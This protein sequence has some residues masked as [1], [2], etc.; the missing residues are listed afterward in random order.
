MCKRVLSF[1]FQLGKNQTVRFF[2]SVFY[3]YRVKFIII[4]N[5]FIFL[6]V[7]NIEH[8]LNAYLFFKVAILI[9]GIL[10]IVAAFL[11]GVLILEEIQGDLQYAFFRIYYCFSFLLTIGLLTLLIFLLVKIIL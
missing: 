6:A 4:F 1:I 11:N 3:P 10:F 7:Y 8:I 9:I 5:V 2:K